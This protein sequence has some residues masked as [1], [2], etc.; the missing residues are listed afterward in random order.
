MKTEAI[1]IAAAGL[2]AALP[3]CTRVAVDPIEVK[4]IHITMDVNIRVE[5]ELDQFFAYEDKLLTGDSPAT[6][7]KAATERE[8][9]KT[10]APGAEQP[11]SEAE[12]E[13]EPATDAV[14]E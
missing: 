7:P 2:A 13:L 8:P 12:T 9:E 1:M 14:A 6:S 10:V 4:P 5:R 3:G 11:A